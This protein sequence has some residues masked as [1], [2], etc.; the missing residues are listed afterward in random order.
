M[1]IH[2]L[3]TRFFLSLLV[4]ALLVACSDDKAIDIRL[5]DSSNS[6][7]KQ[8]T[9]HPPHVYTFG[10]DPR[11][12]PQEDARQYLPFLK[13]LEQSTG[14][15]FTLRFTHKDENI[16]DD[17]GTGILD[18]AAIG[19]TSYI[20]ARE[21]HNYPISPIA[22]GVN[23]QGEAEYRSYFVV[24][25]ASEISSLSQLK[26]HSFA[27][28]GKTSTQG[29]LIP[30]IVMLQN[31][32]SLSQLT[33]YEYTGSHIKCANAVVSGSADVCGMQDTMA[34]NMARQGLLKIIF[35]S[36]Y[37]PSSGI[38]ANERVGKEIIEKVQQAL[39]AFRPMGEHSA[40]LYNWHKTEMPRGFVKATD[41]DYQEMRTWML[42]LGFLESK[43]G[44]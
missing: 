10:F 26:A 17:I 41:Q 39:I 16:A 34:D 30:R 36:G 43:A 24:H 42:K 27:F 23:M 6:S 32:I 19:A 37:Y 33:N 38:V 20:N 5:P 31:G 13:Y 3:T 4:I 15:K 22:R 28:G 14:Y 35:R 44:S 18:F 1:N 8:V 21:V 9:S 7:S 12:S 2:T 11:S 25:P 29:H 40:N